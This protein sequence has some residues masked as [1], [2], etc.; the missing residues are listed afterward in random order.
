MNQVESEQR[1]GMSD[2][3]KETFLTIF[4]IDASIGEHKF[5]EV[6]KFGYVV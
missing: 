5:N 3:N 6:D 1:N 2:T 4:A